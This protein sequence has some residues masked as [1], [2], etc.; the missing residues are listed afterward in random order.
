MSKQNTT[1]NL[2]IIEQLVLALHVHSSSLCV[3]FSGALLAGPLL[4]NLQPIS[5]HRIKAP[6]VKPI[7]RG[8]RIASCRTRHC[9][10]GPKSSAA[11]LPI[12]DFSHEVAP[13]HDPF[14]LCSGHRQSARWPS[15]RCRQHAVQPAY[16]NPPF[17]KLFL[18]KNVFRF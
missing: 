8:K 13:S 5:R 3:H 1:C 17:S 12:I 11:T 4:Q 18:V 10:P 2:Y 16:E 9:V 7:R 14:P 6:R 15:T